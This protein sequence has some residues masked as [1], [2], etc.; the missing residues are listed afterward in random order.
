MQ[1]TEQLFDSLLESVEKKI[2]DQDD[3]IKALLDAN[4]SLLDANKS[5]QDINKILQDANKSLISCKDSSDSLP[6][7][8]NQPTEVNL[9]TNIDLTTL[10]AYKYAKSFQ[11]I[12]RP[13]NMNELYMTCLQTQH[14]LY[15]LQ[16]HVDNISRRN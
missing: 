6:L 7:S 10:P 1:T 16:T 12:K 3:N 2:A 4:K 9:P 15:E 14:L 13:T 5:L 8:D 11:E